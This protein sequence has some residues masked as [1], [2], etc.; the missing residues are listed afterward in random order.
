[1]PIRNALWTV[2]ASPQAL[3]EARLISERVL[4]DMIVTAPRIL[5]DEWMLIGRQAR[6]QLPVRRGSRNGLRILAVNESGP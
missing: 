3:P 1:M 6:R 5:S 4:E 2:G